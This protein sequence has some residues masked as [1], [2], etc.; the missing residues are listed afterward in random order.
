LTSNKPGRFPELSREERAALIKE[1]ENWI[2]WRYSGKWF[3]KVS[4]ALLQEIDYLQSQ[5][6]KD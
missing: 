4:M 1:I 6:K 5:I 3:E 2:Q